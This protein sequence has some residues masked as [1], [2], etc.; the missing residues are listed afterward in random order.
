M[1]KMAQ[2]SGSIE[3][4]T[5][6]YKEER[7]LLR[8][9][10]VRVRVDKI[11]S[12]GRY[13]LCTV[14]QVRRPLFRSAPGSQELVS[15]AHMALNRLHQLGLKPFVSVALRGSVTVFAPL[16]ANDPFRL[17]RALSEAGREDLLLADAEP[18]SGQPAAH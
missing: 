8:R 11:S 2:G 17:R 6:L 13:A 4:I 5:R 10:G 16:D 3:L 7:T 9:K 18:R 14:L 1:S 15:L 12:D